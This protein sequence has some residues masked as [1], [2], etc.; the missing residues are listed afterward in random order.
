[1]T[2]D[3]LLRQLRE[4]AENL[5]YDKVT[6][7][8]TKNRDEE[9]KNIQNQRDV[10]LFQAKEL[11]NKLSNDENYQDF[12]YIKNQSKIYD[13]G[14]RLD[15]A[16]EE[17]AQNEAN[18]LSNNNR[19]DFVNREIAACT[20]LLSEAQN[21]LD[22]YGVELRN[23]G[24]NPTPEQ[25]SEVINKISSA[26]EDMDYLKAELEM[27]N[28][29]LENLNENK[30]ELNKRANT[31]SKTKE[32]YTKL[33]ED[34]KAKEKN[35]KDNIDHT[36][37]DND[38]RKLLQI[39]ASI[40]AFNNREE[41]IS[42]DFPIELET[43]IDD[44]END[45]I[46]NVLDRLEELK[47]KMPE[48]IANKNYENSEE[49]LAENKKMQAEVLMEKLA[50]ED[51]LSNP[52]NYLPSMFSVEAMNYEI[53]N[54]ES[55]INKYDS[56]IQAMEAN[57]IHYENSRK[58]FET[59][60]SDEENVREQLNSQ[61]MD[62]RIKEA[63]LPTEIY[64]QQKDEIA[65]EKK[66]IQKEISESSK[67]IERLTKSA[68]SIDLLVTLAKKDKKNLEN[69]RNN[70]MKLLETKK[71]S[72][73]ER[74]GINKFL[75][76]EDQ[77]KLEALN[78]QLNMLKMRENAIYYDYEEALNNVINN[79]SEKKQTDKKSVVPVFTP[80]IKTKEPNNITPKEEEKSK[81]EENKDNGFVLVDNKDE[82]K[83]Q[84]LV[85][86]NQEQG[87][88]PVADPLIPPVVPPVVPSTNAEEE[89][90]DAVPIPISFW[91]KAK[92]KI[93][94]KLRDKNFM[95]RVKAAIAATIIAL[96]MGLGL[97]RCSDG[98]TEVPSKE[99]VETVDDFELPEYNFEIDDVDDIEDELD[100]ENSKTPIKDTN[101]VPQSKPTSN[102]ENEQVQNPEPIPTPVEPEPES[103]PVDPEPEPTPDPEPEPTPD[104][105]P[106][107]TP[108]PEPEPTPDPE[109]EPT[110]DPEPEPTPDPEPEPTPDPEP[111]E[112]TQE[113]EPGQ[114]GILQTSDGNVA[115]TDN[116]ELSTGETN[117]PQQQVAQEIIDRLEQEGVTV[118]TVAD[119][120]NIT[121]STISDDGTITNTYEDTTTSGNPT[122]EDVIEQ[123]STENHEGTVSDSTWDNLNNIFSQEYS[124]G[125]M[126]R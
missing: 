14:V 41:Y 34:S 54:L 39:Q 109:P 24:N 17:I 23:L 32:G 3:E 22:Q 107:P 60:I 36:K 98:R 1:M 94:D 6:T 111:I 101:D 66:R 106:E 85:P 48:P 59:K 30:E 65:K 26:R 64:E 46:V 13:Y 121:S 88:V 67:K 97:S 57:F 45:K 18:I 62:L 115:V 50:L 25:D 11:E 38:Y 79:V 7:I 118:G 90:K 49:E 95:K 8:T 58:D 70:E 114:V 123:I 125:G 47:A 103:T 35:V 124:E 80:E 53:N 87:L 44:I 120:Q 113:V 63:V 108:D 76:A 56:D 33:L 12:S 9:L 69:L 83:E 73:E 100:D 96:T 116:V 86:T 2:K 82:D 110:P 117:T 119:D 4:I 89:E 105:E 71:K 27:Y 31:L 29:E 51:K 81:G 28:N 84:G 15:R 92:N 16:N 20:A 19:I 37:K 99:V 126:T 91:K 74:S 5:K 122:V 104:P 102:P 77:T 42:F 10:L 78:G 40:D 43:L 75:M 72:F 68:L 52:N 112:K 61:L 93:L 55:N 21:N